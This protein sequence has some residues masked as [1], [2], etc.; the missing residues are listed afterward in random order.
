MTH[1]WLIP[2]SIQRRIRIMIFIDVVKSK[3]A[4]ILNCQHII[5]Y[6][7]GKRVRSCSR[8]KGECSTDPRGGP[9]V[10]QL[11]LPAQAP[12]GWVGGGGTRNKKPTKKNPVVARYGP[13]FNFSKNRSNKY[14]HLGNFSHSS[15]DFW[16]DQQLRSHPK[17]NFC[18]MPDDQ[19]T[20]L[21]DH[22]SHLAI[23]RNEW[24]LFKITEHEYLVT[25]GHLGYLSHLDDLSHNDHLSNFGHLGHFDA[26]SHLGSF[27]WS[28]YGHLSHLD[29]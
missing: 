20:Y 2:F 5:K 3:W 4:I 13:L 28:N 7:S 11:V 22:T 16:D 23:A 8:L 18:K 12:L 29:D 1:I 27:K 26:M 14:G 10:T 21:P 24:M 9:P 6:E 15:N 17:S 25:S 19:M